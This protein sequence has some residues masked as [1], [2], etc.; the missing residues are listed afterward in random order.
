MDKSIV[1][2]YYSSPVGELLLGVYDNQLC[3]ADWRYRKMR[4]A[5]DQRLQKYLKADYQ[6]GEHPVLEQTI[7][8]LEAYF[9]GKLKQFDIPILLAGSKFQQQ[10][11]NALIDI[12]YGTTETYLGLSKTLENV[13]A[14]RAV[15]AA[16][17][18]NALS[19]IVPCHRIIG[20]NGDLIGYAGGLP[21]KKKLLELEGALHQNQLSMF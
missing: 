6:E 8:Q 11:W 18:A 21:A 12:S 19:I 3:I 2:K 5:I 4:S 15:A 13:K 17:G 20:S 1:T 9:T 16:N 14:I 10:V 7:L